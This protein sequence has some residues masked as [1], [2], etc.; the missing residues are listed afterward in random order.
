LGLLLRKDFAAQFPWAV[1]SACADI[2]PGPES[3]KRIQEVGLPVFDSIP[4]MLKDRPEI[5]MIFF[6]CED[7]E[8]A[9]ELR[10]EL[11][12]H[13]SLVDAPSAMFLW[14]VLVSEKLCTNCR[15]GLAHTR[16][17]LD[18]VIEEVS[19][20]IILMD[21]LGK[22]VELNKNVY[23]PLGR[24][25]EDFIGKNRS[26][27]D[28]GGAFRSSPEVCPFDVT[29]K[30]KV[31]ADGVFSRLDENGHMRYLRI[32]TYPVFND[33]GDL[34][35]IM[36]M[37]R[38]I[39]D[40]T[41]MELRLQQSEKLAAI[42]ELSTYIAHEIRNPLFAI[43]GFANSLLRSEH[44]GES[45]REKVGI[46]LKES[47]R[48]DEILK[49]IINFARPT[50]TDETEVDVNHVI[51]ETMSVMGL[52]CSPSGICMSFEPADGVAMVK[53]D[54]ELLKQSIINLL[55]NAME[56]LPG[57]GQI[58]VSTGMGERFVI[59]TV[60]DNGT[61]IAEDIQDKVFNP[62]FST[63]DQGAGLGLAMTKKIVDEM[64]GRV[65]LAGI[66]DKGTTVVLHLPPVIAS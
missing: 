14:E 44:L 17:F 8:R 6:L 38:D 41:R 11:P 34:T 47:Q 29:L 31:K 4:E 7:Q 32:Y 50:K 3:E 25:K 39:T 52:G 35:H 30:T 22:I 26:E 18:A 16:A 59:V 12:A 21:V 33:N 28:K 23:A 13:V 64:G 54:S 55:K 15:A 62:F 63:K 9:K 48:L 66:P 60:A 43:G 53:G 56:A 49:S 20:D 46:I 51:Q 61:G 36:E 58:H 27:L 65:E 5:N 57:G 10:A 24:S 2:E 19:E 1:L 37:R 40:R 45:D 42:G